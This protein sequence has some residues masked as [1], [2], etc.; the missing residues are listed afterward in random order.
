MRMPGSR[1]HGGISARRPR[2]VCRWSWKR[3]YR[4]P[5]GREGPASRLLLECGRQIV[6]DGFVHHDFVVLLRGPLAEREVIGVD[7]RDHCFAEDKLVKDALSDRNE[8]GVE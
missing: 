1:C 7:V 6:V 8:P 5:S 2:M 4:S 3:W